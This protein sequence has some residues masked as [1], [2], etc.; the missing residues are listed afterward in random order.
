MYHRTKNMSSAMKIHEF[1]ILISQEF[2]FSLSLC[3][4]EHENKNNEGQR[5]ELPEFRVY[6]S[7]CS[8]ERKWYMFYKY[9]R[10]ID[11]STYDGKLQSHLQKCHPL[12]VILI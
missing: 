4:E 1:F 6:I 12:W 10:S 11:Y 3:L 2:H 9:T 8:L 5:P 7:R